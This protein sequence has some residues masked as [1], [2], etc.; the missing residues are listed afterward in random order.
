MARAKGMLNLSGNLEVNAQ[1]PLDARTIVPTE[2]DL[3]VA[4]NF[5]YPYVGLEVYVTGTGKKF[6]LVNLDTTQSSS[7]HEVGEGGGGSGLPSGG[8]A[9]QYLVKQ[10]ATEGDAD[11]QS[12]N[13]FTGATSEAAG[14]A[15]LVPAPAIGDEGK[16]LFGNGS[17]GNIVMPSVDYSQQSV[18]ANIFDTNEK[19][20]GQWTDGKLLYQKTIIVQ[21]TDFVMQ[22]DH[23]YSQAEI[24]L[25]ADTLVPISLFSFA[26]NNSGAVVPIDAFSG[27]AL[28]AHSYELMSWLA[29]KN[30]KL[31]AFSRIMPYDSAYN[32]FY[33]IARYTKS[34][35]SPLASDEKFA[36]LTA[37]GEV[38]YKKQINGSIQIDNNQRH[39]DDLINLASLSIND[40]V[41][42]E[43]TW[44]DSGNTVK[45]IG[46]A[47]TEFYFSIRYNKNTKYLQSTNMGLLNENIPY[48]IVIY[49]TKTS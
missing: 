28:G 32:T 21:S 40:V 38:I 19:V 18:E 48:K 5:P 29:Y 26:K 41:K 25:G 10:S 35:D 13:A 49:Y 27:I 39:H 6:R 47:D 37:S 9:G 30:S 44:S 34:T 17:W 42:I 2:A 7:W 16:V 12:L 33:F 31:V 4:S 36:G 23:S 11:W 24:V 45:N 20:I 1:A 14:A 15:G 43:G 46:S 3:T 8:T 22:P